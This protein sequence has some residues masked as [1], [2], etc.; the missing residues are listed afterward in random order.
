MTART[1]EDLIDQI[2][3]ALRVV[4]DPELGYN[5]IGLG[6]IYH[7]AVEEGG[8]ARITMTTTTRGCPAT[9]YLVDGARDVASGV[10]GIEIGGY[11]SDSRLLPPSLPF[12]FFA[13]AA[14]FHVLLWLVLLF[15]A[16]NATSFAGGLGPVLAAVHL[17]TLG[18]LTTTAIGAAA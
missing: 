18:V 16:G 2:K 6:L 8:V 5:I 7:V 12:R 11:Q 10:S 3:D 13:A 17:L 14:V 1:A 4:I 15:A 9:S